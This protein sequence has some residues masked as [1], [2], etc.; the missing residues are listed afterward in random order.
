MI[1]KSLPI[2][3]RLAK[4]I[5]KTRSDDFIEGLN[6][7]LSLLL[8]VFYALDSYYPGTPKVIVYSEDVILLMMTLDYLLFFF[9]SENRLFYF[10]SFQSM[11]SYIT[12]IP[13]FLVRVGAVI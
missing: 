10:F 3:L 7:I 2:N 11:C 1:N 8:T 12:I 5:A 13:T 4:Y 6:A 9:I